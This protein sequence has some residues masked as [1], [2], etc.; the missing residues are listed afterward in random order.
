MSPKSLKLCL[1]FLEGRLNLML[2][3]HFMKQMPFKL[4]S[5]NYLDTDTQNFL[6][7]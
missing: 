6:Y 5:S 4:V 3:Q 1:Q 2:S 7:S